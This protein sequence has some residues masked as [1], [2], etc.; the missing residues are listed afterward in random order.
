MLPFVVTCHR[1][2]LSF[3]LSTRCMDRVLRRTLTDHTTHKYSMSLPTFRLCEKTPCS[4]KGGIEYDLTWDGRQ[5]VRR[6]R[7]GRSVAGKV[8]VTEPHCRDLQVCRP[9]VWVFGFL[10][11]SLADGLRLQQGRRSHGWC[12]LGNGKLRVGQGPSVLVD[13]GHLT[14]IKA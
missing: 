5:Q 10:R 4:P 1:G 3:V 7:T 11:R 9:V 6:S 8:P 2:H 12:A 14:I 13:E